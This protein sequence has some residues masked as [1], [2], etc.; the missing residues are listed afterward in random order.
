MIKSLT[1]T[2]FHAL[3]SEPPPR[4]VVTSLYQLSILT[5]L[6]TPAN[7]FKE[8]LVRVLQD[9]TCLGVLISPE[10]PWALER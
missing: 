3:N 2:L 10:N 9:G 1:L 5:S 4:L 6:H 8:I 7:W